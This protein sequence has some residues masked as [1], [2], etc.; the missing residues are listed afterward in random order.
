MATNKS[1]KDTLPEFISDIF[2]QRSLKEITR[3]DKYCKELGL[4]R[5]PQKLFVMYLKYRGCLHLGIDPTVNLSA[6]SITKIFK[7][8]GYP[9]MEK[10]YPKDDDW[11][12]FIRFW[13]PEKLDNPLEDGLFSDGINLRTRLWKIDSATKKKKVA[14]FCKC[15]THENFPDDNRV[16]RLPFIFFVLPKNIGLAVMFFYKPNSFYIMKDIPLEAQK[17]KYLFKRKLEPD[18]IF[19]SG[20][21]NSSFLQCN[22]ARY[23][24]LKNT[25]EDMFRVSTGINGRAR[26]SISYLVESS[27]ITESEAIS[28]L[29]KELYRLV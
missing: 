17:P 4:V 10:P 20:T 3:S 5:D 8:N 6:G 29:K 1:N 25:L 12:L 9:V 11:E 22:S 21:S 26:Y 19:N 27:F 2:A 23:L 28:Y 14:I 13:Q 15:N 7:N 16:V 24:D 18:F